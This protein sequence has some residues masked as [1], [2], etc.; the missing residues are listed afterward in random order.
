MKQRTRI[1][2]G[3]RTVTRAAAA[4]LAVASIATVGGCAFGGPRVHGPT[5]PPSPTSSGYDP[6]D[7]TPSEDST[8]DTYSPSPSPTEE[9]YDPD[10]R[11]D[12]R[13]SSCDFSESL[14][15]FT[16]TL[17][18][19]N[20]SSSDSFSYDMD[21]RWMKAK[22]ADGKMYGEHKRSIIVGPSDTETYTAEYTVNQSS[23]ARFWFTC[24]ISQAEKS[25]M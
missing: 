19:T 7:P 14:H 10:G 9:T 8:Y 25:R 4:G 17:S 24:E 23:F 3:R 18:I 2:I 20:P 22:P 16:Y 12:V 1:R 5:A 21:I 11:S 15:K 6:N 13:G